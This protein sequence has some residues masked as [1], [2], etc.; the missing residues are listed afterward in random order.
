MLKKK[1][2]DQTWTA[3][4][5]TLSPTDRHINCCNTIIFKNR[6]VANINMVMIHH[7]LPKFVIGFHR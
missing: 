3:V 7:N 5:L 2:S 4:G 1:I 6:V